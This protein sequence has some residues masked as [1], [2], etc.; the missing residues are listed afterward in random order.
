MKILQRQTSLSIE[1]TLTSLQVDFP[2]SLFPLPESEKEAKMSARYGLK[3]IEQSNRLNRLSLWQKMFRDLLLSK[4]ELSSRGYALTWKISATKY[5]RLLFRL[6]AKMRHT[7]ESDFGYWLTLI[8][9]DAIMSKKDLT[10]L[11]KTNSGSYRL[12]NKA[13]NTSNAGLANQ[14]LVRYLPTL[15]RSDYKGG[16]MKRKANCKG[17]LDDLI[18][19]LQSPNGEIF[20]LHPHFAEEL[21]GFPIG[22]TELKHSETQ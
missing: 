9:S 18:E 16:S 6:V 11:V 21:M 3:C 17:N 14:V 1:E 13:G 5:K 4:A 15:Q 12:K 19:N 22:W 8:S 20:R 7:K 2:A 10:K